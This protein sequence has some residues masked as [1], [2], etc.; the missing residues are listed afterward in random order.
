MHQSQESW[1]GLDCIIVDQLPSGRVPQALVILAHGF[2]APG[3][4][5]VGLA[6]VL[7]ELEPQ[8]AEGVR[9]VFPAARLSLEEYGYPE[10]R[11]WWPLNLAQLQKDLALGRFED[12]RQAIPPGLEET[13]A[14]LSNLLVEASAATGVPVTQCV[15]GG[16]SQGA[17]ATMDAAVHCSR[18]LAGLVLLSGAVVNEAAW[19]T[20]AREHASLPVFQSHG[21]YDVVLPYLAGEWLRAVWTDVGN[22][23]EFVPFDGGHQIPWPVLSQLARFLLRCVQESR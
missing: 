20:G 23:V 3:T 9:F 19:R 7:F 8:L 15:L 18:S 1:G 14:A 13:R 6:E 2:G 12:V 16:F 22:P 10:G 17:M 21:R 5:L 4:D 11:A